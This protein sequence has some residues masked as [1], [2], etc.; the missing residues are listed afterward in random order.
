MSFICPICQSTEFEYQLTCKDFTVSKEEFNIVSCKNCNFFITYPH[1]DEKQISKYYQSENYI[2]HSDKKDSFFDKLYHLVRKYTLKQKVNLV[3][4]YVPHGTI[5]DIGC[6]TGYFLNEC[7]NNN[8]DTIGI[9]P[10]EIARISCQKKG[11]KVFENINEILNQNK[12]INVVSLWHVLEHIH[13]PKD[14]LIKIHSLL[15]TKGIL[16][17]ALPNRNSFDAKYYKQF[18][19][20]YDV[21]RHIY[22]FTKKNVIDIT[23]NKFILLD[24]YPMYFDSSYVSILSEKYK[25]SKIPL[26]KGLC[27]GLYSNIKSIKNNEYSSLIY[28]LQKI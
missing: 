14:L 23:K 5:L 8:F 17:L 27:T 9:E 13:Q 20:G 12:S 28:V 6:G 22:H 21:P 11:L 2:S 16:I 26:L 7:K 3:K 10:N 1:P 4:R 19:A 18:W 15:S 24:T 25:G